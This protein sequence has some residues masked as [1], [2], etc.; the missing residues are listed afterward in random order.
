MLRRVL[1]DATGGV[2]TLGTGVCVGEDA[3]C[4]GKRK[5]SRRIFVGRLAGVGVDSALPDGPEPGRLKE[6]LRDEAP[7]AYVSEHETLLSTALPPSPSLLF[8]IPVLRT[9]AIAFI[10]HAPFCLG[11]FKCLQWAKTL[12]SNF[13]DW[14]VFFFCGFIHTPEAHHTPTGAWATRGYVL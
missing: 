4:E 3:A 12:E 10:K 5:E 11:L 7:L 1:A 13:F 9:L 2:M 14:F 8:F 6:E